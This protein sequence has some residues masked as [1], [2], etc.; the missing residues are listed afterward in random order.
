[1]NKATRLLRAH[2]TDRRR[3]LYFAAIGAWL[4]H[5]WPCREHML[6]ANRAVCERNMPRVVLAAVL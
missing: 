4:A 3:E 1:M 5:K 6:A 2:S